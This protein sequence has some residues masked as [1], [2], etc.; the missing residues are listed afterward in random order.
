M[1]GI[2]RRGCK[3]GDSMDLGSDMCKNIPESK[4]GLK[5]ILCIKREAKFYDT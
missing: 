4:W 1:S 5:S 2:G 3:G